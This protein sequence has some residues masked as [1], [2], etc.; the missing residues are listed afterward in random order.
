MSIATLKMPRLGETM[1]QGEIVAWLVEVG[2]RFERG[3]P[4]LEVET[5][6]TVVEYPALGGGI[7]AEILAGEGEAVTVGD[8]IARID[9]GDAEDWTGAEQADAAEDGA[10]PAAQSGTSRAPPAPDPAAKTRAQGERPRATPVARRTARRAGIDLA[11]LTGT[12]R[13]GRIEARDIDAAA[14]GE[15]DTGVRFSHDIA[16]VETGPASGPQFLLIHGFGG[17]HTTFAALAN[18]LK[19]AGCRTVACD[20]PGHGATRIEA[21]QPEDL[22]SNLTRF[23]ISQFGQSPLHLVAHSLGAV[24]ALALAGAVKLASLTLIAPL[25]LQPQE[26]PEFLG[27]MASPASVED[28]ERLLDHLTDKPSGLSQSAITAIHGELSRGRLVALAQTLA[29][30]EMDIRAALGQV[31]R[32]SPAR[33]L[34]GENDRILGRV[35]AFTLPPEI[36]VH[37]FRQTGHM[38]H[39][40]QTRPVLDILLAGIR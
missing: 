7:L 36:A 32:K 1:E 27:G 13:R 34:I 20:L 26:N 16:Y 14:R 4:I 33:V 15:P 21:G 6:K 25:G 11:S 10:G 38:P 23:A 19:K 39:W 30:Q 9:L 8:P 40:E 37:A 24:P 5:D 18:G 29:A 28:L 2:E 35:D 12:G 17:D 22:S 31:A 3:E